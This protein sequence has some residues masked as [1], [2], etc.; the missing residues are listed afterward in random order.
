MATALQIEDGNRLDTVRV[1]DTSAIDGG[2]RVTVREMI[3][4]YA[5]WFGGRDVAIHA[6]R[7][8]ARRALPGATGAR[9][10]REWYAGGQ[11]HATFEVMGVSQ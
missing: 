4:G 5:D 2:L 7:K 9:L 1:S 11:N 3:G 6:M 8:T 10:V